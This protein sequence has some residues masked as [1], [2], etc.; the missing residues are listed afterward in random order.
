MIVM[1]CKKV[2]SAEFD[3]PLLNGFVEYAWFVGV[4]KSTNNEIYLKA[5]KSAKT[6]SESLG[7]IGKGEFPMDIV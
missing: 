6:F 7:E 1:P 5:R 3:L 2:N 4:L